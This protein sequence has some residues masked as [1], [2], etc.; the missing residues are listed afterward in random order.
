MA[1]SRDPLFYLN[2]FGWTYDPRLPDA[3]LVPFVTYPFQDVALMLLVES[4]RDGRSLLIEKSRDQGASWLCLMAMEWYWHF[5][6]WQSFLLASRKEDYVDKTGD[7]DSLMQ[8]LDAVLRL[9]PNWLR[10]RRVE[11]NVLHMKN[12][13]NGSMIDGESTNS[14]L[15]RGGRRT[16]ILLDEFAAV[17]NG[18]EVLSATGNA[19]NCRIFN[20]TPKGTGNAFFDMRNTSIRVLTLPWTL[21]PVQ[22][23]GLYVGQ[24]GLVRSPYYDRRVDEAAHP[25]EVPQELD[26]DYSASDFEFFE[27]AVVDRLCVETARDP[28]AHGDLVLS[29]NRWLFNDGPV[30]DLSLWFYPVGPHDS[31]RLDDLV[32][33]VDVA[34]GSAVASRGSSNS[35]ASVV[36][37]KTG[38]KIAEMV[39][40]TSLPHKWAAKC[41]G[42]C[43]WL[44]GNPILIWEAN[45]PGT[46]FA[47]E[48][49]AAG[50][51]NVFCRTLGQQGWFST[52]DT[53][54]DLL[55]AYRK[56]LASGAFVNRSLMALRECR[57]YV[58][59][60]SGSVTHSRSEST[61]DMSGARDNHGDRVIADA[62]ANWVRR[63]F[64]TGGLMQTADRD[65]NPPAGSLAW[66]RLERKRGAIRG[67]S[68]TGTPRA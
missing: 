17:E 21:H 67:I 54:R 29:E 39:S 8:K 14:D 35:V 34:A 1:C 36:S 11:R 51:V 68:L 56:D 46:I 37:L 7:M 18:Y 64:E 25:R 5:R 20:S 61:P 58:Y 41:V 13:D 49:A 62:L 50:Y 42:L 23:R 52:R 30:G 10:P 45:G 28:L 43:R 27:G 40:S 57:D 55:G 65:Q 33:G 12:L 24:D 22:R 4:I 19:T 16:A 26:I 48:V 9:Q 6:P 3:P 2:V 32:V 59:S 38:E 53:K 60:R 44:G 31:G 66:R 15:G 47:Q 63:Q